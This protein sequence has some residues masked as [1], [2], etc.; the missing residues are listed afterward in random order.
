MYYDDVQ[1]V[2]TLQ[3]EEYER[4]AQAAVRTHQDVKRDAEF[5]ASIEDEYI[6]KVTPIAPTR[7]SAATQAELS[8]HSGIWGNRFAALAESSPADHATLKLFP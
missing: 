2:K 4:V 1:P 6:D 5:P 3:E 8:Y 7:P